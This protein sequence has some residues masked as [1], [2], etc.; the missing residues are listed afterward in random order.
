MGRALNE[1]EQKAFMDWLTSF[2]STASAAA[3]LGVDPT[4]FIRWRKGTGMHVSQYAALLR[5]LSRFM[6]SEW[7]D[8]KP[9]TNIYSVGC[10]DEGFEIS[11]ITVKDRE[12]AEAIFNSIKMYRMEKDMGFPDEIINCSNK[13][14][15]DLLKGYYRFRIIHPGVE[16]LELP[17]KNKIKKNKR[18][19]IK[20]NKDGS[21]IVGCLNVNGEPVE[22]KIDDDEERANSINAEIKTLSD[23]NM[24]PEDPKLS[25]IGKLAYK[26][27]CGI[28]KP[29]IPLPDTKEASILPH[30]KITKLT[31][32]HPILNALHQRLCGI[33]DCGMIDAFLGNLGGLAKGLYQVADSAL[34]EAHSKTVQWVYSESPSSLQKMIQNVVPDVWT[35]KLGQ[36]RIVAFLVDGKIEAIECESEEEANELHIYLKGLKRAAK[37]KTP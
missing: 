14:G 21:F 22:I 34:T 26:M 4:A 9:G 24:P 2:E 35:D 18:S 15:S 8:H 36:K 5:Q 7:I 27:Y 16:N 11:Q 31:N 30:A 33:E 6:P 32:Q 17:K 20:K 12:T 10:I 23:F 29:H 1:T 19:W 28:E 13:I 3:T 25:L 37:G